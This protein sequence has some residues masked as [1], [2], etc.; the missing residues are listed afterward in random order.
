[1]DNDLP[2]SCGRVQTACVQH[3]FSRRK[4]YFSSAIASAMML[5]LPVA[6]LAQTSNSDGST[7]TLFAAPPHFQPP[8]QISGGGPRSRDPWDI[9]DFG[10]GV[11]AGFGEGGPVYSESPWTEDYS[12]LGNP[13]LLPARK[14]GFWD[15][16]KFIPLNTSKDVYI[17]FSGEE[18]L[19]DYYENQ[20]VLNNLKPESQSRN[21]LRSMYGADIHIGTIFR[22]FV[23]LTD[24]ADF[25][26]TAGGAHG[27]GK[28]V[29][30]SQRSRLDV[31]Q[32]FVEAKAVI[33]GAQSGVMFGRQDYYEG[34][35]SMGHPGNAV[36]V[37]TSFDGI[38]I[39]AIWPRFRIDTFDFAGVTLVNGSL[40]QNFTNWQNRW[41]GI[42][43][44]APLPASTFMGKKSQL[45]W[46]AWYWDY[47]LNPTTQSFFSDTGASPK[48][49]KATQS[50][51]ADRDYIAARLWGEAGPFNI[52]WTFAYE[53]GE[54]KVTGGSTRGISA[55]GISTRTDYQFQK[56]VFLR[57]SIGTE[58]N[59]YSGGDLRKTKG[60][61]G[62]FTI[63]TSTPDYYSVPEYVIQQNV[64]EIAPEATFHILPNLQLYAQLPFWWRA[65]LDDT[66]Y[67]TGEVYN[68]TLGSGR[69]VGT[70]PLLSLHW[71]AT[72]YLSV[73]ETASKFLGSKMMTSN[74]NSDSIWL[75]SNIDYRF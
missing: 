20:P 54:Q 32:A 5:A 13:S 49:F 10:E 64:F 15:P 75:L 50:G 21:V 72:R 38:R 26:T 41:K 31:Q 68:T 34:P 58:I 63:P 73:A 27:G 17:S 67:G 8:G 33:L 25:T 11:A 28:A 40:F 16:V 74:G 69:Y 59:Y 45:F 9:W 47:Y 52:D 55:Y 29:G 66:V 37:H 3:K 53:D 46:D 18:R 1:M 60:E 14:P 61:I 70:M 48:L 51:P 4:Y 44:S 39:Y 35:S 2:N 71:Q 23:Q 42:Y 7:V 57:P 65:S 24:S 30:G 56:S 12:Y 36:G 6:A 22:A 19:K 43:I 62:T